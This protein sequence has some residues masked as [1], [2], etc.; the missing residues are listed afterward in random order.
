ML[1]LGTVEGSA[2]R[3]PL[4]CATFRRLIPSF[5]DL[6]FIGSIGRQLAAKS[7]WEFVALLRHGW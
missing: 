4:I 6:I 2:E 7:V 3:P 1:I 5:D